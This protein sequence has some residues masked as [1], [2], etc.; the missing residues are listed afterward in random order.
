M[1]QKIIHTTLGLLLILSTGAVD[2]SAKDEPA[3][4]PLKIEKTFQQEGLRFQ[5]T[6]TEVE[7]R[8]SD[9][10]EYH[11]VTQVTNTTRKSIDYLQPQCYPVSTSVYA[12]SSGESW[13]LPPPE[14]EPACTP[15]VRKRVLKPGKTHKQEEIF[16]TN[17][18][19]ETPDYYELLSTFIV[20]IGASDKKPVEKPVQLKTQFYEG[21]QLNS[22]DIEIQSE[23]TQLSPSSYQ[24][25]VSG[26]VPNKEIKRLSLKIDRPKDTLRINSKSRAFSLSK[27][28]R[29]KSE[30]PTTGTLEIVYADGLKQIYEIPLDNNSDK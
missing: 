13:L 3:S 5:L 28:V 7:N 12:Y 8:D 18:L 14:D 11:V 21:F 30:P 26:E 10:T 6:V 29:T 1:L 24:I 9:S 16:R 27:K 19:P 17:E 4:S 22:E 25:K 2:V 15:D 23:W 20:N